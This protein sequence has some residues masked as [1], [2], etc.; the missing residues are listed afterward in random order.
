MNQRLKLGL[1]ILL[2]LGAAMACAQGDRSGSGSGTIVT[3]GETTVEKL[4]RA[5]CRRLVAC[6]GGLE[7]EACL[8]G[9]YGQDNIDVNVGLPNSSQLFGEY[10]ALERAGQILGNAE[11]SERCIANIEQLNCADSEV[12]AAY[13]PQTSNPFRGVGD[14]FKRA[15]GLY[16]RRY[17]PDVPTFRMAGGSDLFSSSGHCRQSLSA[18]ASA[19]GVVPDDQLL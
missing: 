19:F 10:I 1:V 9:V 8:D 11:E 6:H 14:V 15:D 2:T 13:L 16:M 3:G 5:V 7:T 17:D 18:S 4:A 12:A